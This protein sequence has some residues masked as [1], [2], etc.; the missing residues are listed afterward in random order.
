MDF[1]ECARGHGQREQQPTVEDSGE[2]FLEEEEFQQ[3]FEG[4]LC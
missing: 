1:K 2:S 4:M 3:D